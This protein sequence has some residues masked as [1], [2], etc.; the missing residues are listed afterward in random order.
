[1]MCVGTVVDSLT[2]LIHSG[3]QEMG[4]AS[5]TA[6]VSSAAALAIGAHFCD[7]GQGAALT[8]RRL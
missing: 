2:L 6:N 3:L 7:N 5:H 8:P 4:Q 1:M